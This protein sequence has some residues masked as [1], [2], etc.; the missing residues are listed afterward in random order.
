MA[1]TNYKN[2]K[3]IYQNPALLKT[4]T[5]QNKS[6]IVVSDFHGYHYPLDKVKKYYLNEYDITYILGDATDRGED[7]RGSGGIKLLIEIMEL[8]KLYPGRI[9]YIPGNHDEFLLGYVRSKYHID[10]YYEYN[11]TVNLIHNG[12]DAT[13]DELNN[14]EKNNPRKFKELIEWLGKQP[15]QR[16]HS[17]KGKNYVLGHALFNQK[18]Y[19]I[20]PNYTLENYFQEAQFS[21]T[22]KMAKDVLWFRKFKNT[23][24]PQEMPSSDKI[25][26]IGHTIEANIRGKD[27][28]L[29]DSNGKTLKVYCVD[30]GIA[31][32]GEMLKYDG[33]EQVIRTI[34]LIHNN[35]S[36]ES[37]K[38][39]DREEILNNYIVCK[40]LNERK[41][42][43]YKLLSGSIPKELTETECKN[44]I[45]KNISE[46]IAKDEP[47][48]RNIYIK[49]ILFEF[50]LE[51]Q[52]K[53]MQEKYSEP[54]YAIYIAIKMLDT[55]LN[56]TNDIEYITRNGNNGKGNYNHITAK[57]YARELAKIIGSETIKE[58]LYL[59][60]FQTVENYAYKKYLSA[61]NYDINQIKK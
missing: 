49:T 13:I 58:V 46:N 37:D 61:N 42:G 20:N 31:Y 4:T 35:T 17:Y 5:N 32:N 54:N 56:G 52:I 27:I 34:L 8:S 10:N 28:N 1:M 26:V 59:H 23:Y 29:T 25:M 12:G 7:K 22:R 11:Y 15:I 14:L 19:D 18:L 57:N 43:L 39:L 47:Q 45:E 30:G 44:I 50:I 6:F 16:T 38:L 3:M 51:N 55:F 21:E 33:K 60:G 36:K 2:I 41:Q 53:R 9:I 40:I 24:N 48:K